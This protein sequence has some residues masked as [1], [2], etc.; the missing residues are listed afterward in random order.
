MQ[1]SFD[2]PLRLDFKTLRRCSSLKNEMLNDLNP[3]LSSSY[4]VE[5]QKENEGLFRV[6]GGDVMFIVKNI[7]NPGSSTNAGLIRIMNK[8]R[9][10][11]IV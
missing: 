7:T 9:S 8:F 2:T 1:F 5:C 3:P 11:D 10:I 4:V 6:V